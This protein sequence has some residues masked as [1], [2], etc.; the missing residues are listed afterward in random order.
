MKFKIGVLS[1]VILLVFVSSC[2]VQPE[3]IQPSCNN[4]YFEFRDGECCLDKDDNNIC[5]RDEEVE[6]Q[7][8]VDSSQSKDMLKTGEKT[9]AKNLNKDDV[10]GADLGNIIQYFTAFKFISLMGDSATADSIVGISMIS[11][12]MQDKM[13]VEPIMLASEVEDLTAQNIISVGNACENEITAKLLNTP[14]NNCEKGTEKGKGYIKLV[15][16]GNKFALLIYGYTSNDTLKAAA[17]FSDLELWKSG[18]ISNEFRVAIGFSDDSEG[19][20]TTVKITCVDC[21]LENFE[22]FGT[23]VEISTDNI[24]IEDKNY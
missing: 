21:N 6:L 11:I 23:E 13:D 14:L 8:G 3:P 24:L 1:L 12:M 7:M 4:P 10:N 9:I 18:K 2:V 16:N 22:L 17:F 5:D 19:G 15:P 20:I